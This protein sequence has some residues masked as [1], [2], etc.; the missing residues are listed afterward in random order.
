MNSTLIALF[1]VYLF[2][3][4]GYMAKTIFKEKIDNQ[5]INI[6][7][8]Y[9]MQP[10]LMFW[11]ILGTTLNFNHILSPL[12]YLIVI[13]AVLVINIAL[14]KRFFIDQKE[15][16][17][18][19]V[20]ALIG[21]TGN[22]GIPLGIALFGND[23][24]IYTTI[25]NL[26]NVIILYTF[27]TYFYSRGNFS[28]AESIKNIFKL[29]ALW[30]AAIA[31]TLNINGYIPSEDIMKILQMG[32]FGSIMIQLILFGIYMQGIKIRTLNR[33]LITWV[34]VIKFIILPL[35][36]LVVMSFFEISDMVKWIIILE[37]MVPIAV[38]NVNLSALYDCKERDVTALVF[39]SS[40]IFLVGATLFSYVLH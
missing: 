29:P 13:I 37:L 6:L 17:I 36:A 9:F 35:M 31:L 2:I 24:I 28:A 27:G 34:S 18:A 32:A 8:I 1:G 11:G 20:A 4:V 10:F 40:I 39:I 21:N 12:I 3:V 30:S 26:A 33:A 5:S 23:S 7:S 16:S 25:I 15:R 14:A 22:L 38:N 19:T